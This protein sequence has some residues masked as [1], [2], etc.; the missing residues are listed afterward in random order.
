MTDEISLRACTPLLASKT[1]WVYAHPH[2]PSRLLKVHKQAA[3]PG[4]RDRFMYRTG[5]LRDLW[6]W[7]D[8]H[9]R[10]TD[11]M[12]AYI[13]PIYGVTRTDLGLALEVAAIYDAQGALA[14]TLR[15]L[16][17]QGLMT[18]ARRQS[19]QVLLTHLMQT[20]ILLGDLNQDN[21]V[22]EGAGGAQE[23]WRM[24]D[25]LGE[26]TWI[27]IQSWLPWVAR[28]QR[29]RFVQKIRQKLNATR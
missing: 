8:A 10:A 14:P 15:Q 20:Q 7:V 26:R 5:L 16:F 11:P 21:L 17:K 12:L 13:A 4:R 24:V 19:L 22:L 2:D 29:R 3:A 27:P 1:R 23:Q 9:Y 18:P 25:G 28:R 6:V